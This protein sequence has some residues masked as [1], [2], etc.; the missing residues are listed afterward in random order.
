MTVSKRLL[1]VIIAVLLFV[2]CFSIASAATYS[3]IEL[4][5]PYYRQRA[6]GMCS[7]CAF[8]MAEAYATGYGANDDV[9]YQAIRTAHAPASDGGY[10]SDPYRSPALIDGKRYKN[11]ST[12]YATIYSYLKNGQPVVI[13]RNGSTMH[14]AVIYGYTGRTDKLETSGFQVINGVRTDNNNYVKKESLKSFLSASDAKL[15]YAVVRVNGV[16]AHKNNTSYSQNMNSYFANCSVSGITETNATIKGI[17]TNNTSISSAGFYIGTDSANLKK[18]S[19]NLSGGS[20]GATTCRSIFYSMNKWYGNLKPGTRYYYKLYY[21]KGGKEYTSPVNWFITKG[22]TVSLTSLTISAKPYKLNYFVGE[23]LDTAGLELMASFSDGTSRLVTSGF[24][25]AP[26]TFNT[27]GTQ[28][29]TVTYGGK[30]VSFDVVVKNKGTATAQMSDITV[31]KGDTFTIPVTISTES[32]ITMIEY[33]LVYNDTVLRLENAD[34]TING[35]A[36]VANIWVAPFGENINGQILELKFTLTDIPATDTTEIGINLNVKF[37]GEDEFFKVDCPAAVVTVD[38][39]DE[40]T[41]EDGSSGEE[42]SSDEK[43]PITEDTT[44]KPSVVI[45]KGDLNLDGRINASDARLALRI[46]AQLD[47]ADGLLFTI[48]DVNEDGK[49]NAIDARKI[50]RVAAQLEIM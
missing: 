29:V 34:W 20:D 43:E 4:N 19:K 42:D 22:H 41:T 26:T 15:T 30:T 32:E 21:I 7:F 12:D 50:L 9:V 45:L 24:T 31:K 6:S 16:L 13:Y 18:V 27:P 2:S 14:W 37:K 36:T 17:F 28:T 47:I 44:T 23:T 35:T 11:I 39:P 49:I 25:C 40:T 38:L 33:E 48:G 3:K 1:S 8:S 10:I 46:A 5:V